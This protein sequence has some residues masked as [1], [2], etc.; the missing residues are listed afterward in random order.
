MPEGPAHP[1]PGGPR[2]RHRRTLAHQTGLLAVGIAVVTALLA[3]LLTVG[4]TRATIT[5]SARVTLARTADSAAARVDEGVGL[6]AQARAVRA[7]GSLGVQSASVG[8]GGG[9]T[10][11]S[12]LARAALTPE[13]RAVLLSGRAV[14]GSEVVGGARVLLEGRPT[15]RGGILLVQRQS[16]ATAADDRLVR[17]VMLALGLAALVA[18]GV[19]VV[20]SRRLARPLR[21]TAS[22]ARLLAAGQRDLAVPVDGP[23]EVAEVATALNALSSS[24]SRSERRQ[25]DFLLT[26]SHDLR[27][28][29]TGIRGYAESLATG[30]VPPQDTARVGEV[31]VG[32][33]ARLERLVADLL[34]LARLRAEQPSVSLSRVDL[35]GLGDEV[36]SVWQARCQAAGV[37]WRFEHDA[38]PVWALTDATRL[39]QLVEGLLENALRV[40]PAGRPVVLQVRPGDRSGP[41]G[42]WV[43]EVRDGGP[44]LTDEDIAVAF[45][46]AVL[47]ERYRGVRPVGTGLG[48]AIV[49]RLAALL[50]ATVAA[51]H[52]PEGGARFT[53]TGPAAQAGRVSDDTGTATGATGSP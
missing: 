14:S 35:V 17:R 49:A 46:P 2:G 28:P 10:A 32:E 45:E 13:R 47:H 41:P 15:T 7:L 20:V 39:R 3:G 42:A 33:T 27:T 50:G 23:V 37:G 1:T 9:V 31:L 5:E 29:L 4:L 44:G 43:V 34:D 48:L 36:E 16:D 38:P 53:V 22:V 11:T 30:V 12:P 26:V 19:S 52:A 18:V 51:G 25:R 40:T 8:P 6:A 21:R 24:L